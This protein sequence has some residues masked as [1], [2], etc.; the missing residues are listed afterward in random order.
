MEARGTPSDPNA[1][2]LPDRLPALDGIRGLAVL[3]VI[4]H[5]TGMFDDSRG[6]ISLRS[7]HLIHLGWTGVQLFFVLSGF[8]ITRLLL[9]S[10]SA[11]NYYS[12]FYAKR[13]LRIFPLYYATLIFLFVILPLCG[14]STS[15]GLDEDSQFSKQIWLWLYL[16]NWTAPLGLGGGQLFHFWSLAVEEQFYVA[17]PFIVRNMSIEALARVC[18]GLIIAAPLLRVGLIWL[19]VSP[20]A[21]YTFTVSRM[22]A[23]A[24]GALAAVWMFHP[25]TAQR[26][27]SRRRWLWPATG[28]LALFGWLSTHGDAQMSVPSQTFGYSLLAATCMLM[29]LAAA[30]GHDNPSSIAQRLLCS[31]FLRACG[32]YSYAMYVLHVPIHQLVGRPW[33]A[34]HHDL[35]HLSAGE[36]AA[37]VMALSAAS[38]IAAWL[39]YQLLERHFLRLKRHFA[40]RPAAARTLGHGPMT[41]GPP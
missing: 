20:V 15:G 13:V 7:A 41:A 12:S 17:W 38:F 3:V 10:R 8:L 4:V 27:F 23:L 26:V 39:S 18:V 29:V 21:I 37:Y 28:G 16:S 11:P 34:R 36:A 32:K 40:A 19:G 2:Q 9:A 5:N 35:A 22:D 6:G 30:C 33:M 14:W 1:W 31:R 25:P 24:F